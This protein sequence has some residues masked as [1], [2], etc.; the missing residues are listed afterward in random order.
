MRNT[1]MKLLKNIMK[2]QKNAKKK[3]KKDAFRGKI[4]NR[5]SAKGNKT[6]KISNNV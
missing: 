6:K 1:L 3:K 4:V 5:I 2:K